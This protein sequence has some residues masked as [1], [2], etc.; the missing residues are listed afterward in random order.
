M[1]N[2]NL[3]SKNM[4]LKIMEDNNGYLTSR[5]VTQKGISREYINILEKEGR[6]EKVARGVYY[7][8]K[9]SQFDDPFLIFQLKYPD[10]VYSHFTALSFH[11]MT[12]AIPYIKEI[13]IKQGNYRKGY[14]DC[15][16]FYVKDDEI[17][18]LGKDQVKT[19]YGNYVYAYDRERCICDI[20]RSI[21]R[22]DMEQ[23]KK[24]L[25]KYS[26]KLDYIKLSK[27]AK[28]MN[29]SDKVNDYVGRYI[30]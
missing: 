19:E 16:V 5:E 24:V 18:N 13:T 12:E 25:R 30:D 3:N 10:A 1:K 11:E 14:K 20:I 21:N 9:T 27:Y 26:N 8:S 2:K 28:I 4:I 22:E 29:I 15:Q 7:D 6:I 17:L 23:V